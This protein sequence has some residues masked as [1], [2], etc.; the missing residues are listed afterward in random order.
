VSAGDGAYAFVGEVVGADALGHGVAGRG[1]KEFAGCVEGVRVPSG[2]V[3]ALAE[4]EVGVSAFAD[5]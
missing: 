2:G 5:A 1:D 4:D 3:G